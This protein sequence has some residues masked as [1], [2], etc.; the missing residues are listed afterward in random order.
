LFIACKHGHDLVNVF[1][2]GTQNINDA[3]FLGQLTAETRKLLSDVFLVCDYQGTYDA[4]SDLVFVKTGNPVAT[5]LQTFMYWA[6]KELQLS[7][8]KID[9]DQITLNSY[10]GVKE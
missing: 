7:P 9:N 1:V 10:S 4:F 2:I 3:N 6:R 8:L 5:Q